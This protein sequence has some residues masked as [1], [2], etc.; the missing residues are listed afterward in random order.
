MQIFEPKTATQAKKL[1]G[2]YVAGGAD[3]MERYNLGLINH[4]L[5][6]FLIK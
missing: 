6:L 2:E 4:D 1:I 3:V 5:K